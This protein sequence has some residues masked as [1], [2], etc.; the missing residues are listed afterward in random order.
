M[1]A[2]VLIAGALLAGWLL[3]TVDADNTSKHANLSAHLRSRHC[4]VAE[5]ARHNVVAY[6]C[7]L[8][9]AG[10]YVSAEQLGLE[11]LGKK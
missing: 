7:D 10:E 3:S 5:V 2:L 11:A 9:L 4:V 1:L 6:R 8:P